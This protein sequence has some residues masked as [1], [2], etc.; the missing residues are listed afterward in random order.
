MLDSLFLKGSSTNVSGTYTAEQ[1]QAEAVRLLAVVMLLVM[2][3]FL[4]GL[5][6]A[7]VDHWYYLLPAPPVYLVAWWAYQKQRLRLARNILFIGTA[8]LLAWLACTHR[9]LG[10]EYTLLGI[11][12]SAPLVFKKARTVYL[13]VVILIGVFVAYS[14]YDAHTPFVADPS[15]DYDVLKACIGLASASVVF[16][17]IVVYRNR[18]ISYSAAIKQQNIELDVAFELKSTIENELHQKNEE[19]RAMTEQLNWIVVQKSSELQVYLDAIN[20]HIQSAI[21][22][23]HA[24]FV[25]VNEPFSRIS[26]FDSADLMGQSLRLLNPVTEANRFPHD[27]LAHLEQNKVWR[28]ELRYTS[29]QGSFFWCDQVLVPLQRPNADANYFLSLSLP[30][31]ERKLNDQARERTRA[32]LERITFQTSHKVRG[33][34]ARIQGLVNLIQHDLL[35]PDELKMVTE[36]L[37]DC[38]QEVSEATTDLVMFV[39]HHQLMHD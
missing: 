39:N 19:L 21:L 29:K 37:K 17:Q 15:M 34:L 6:L 30:I 35:T 10:L 2:A 4:V 12:C 24:N 26:G 33:P 20:M 1:N 38:T 8:V 3:S 7:R 25:K 16:I 14:W 18:V 9:K 31:T 5:V 23:E 28:G 22:D 13:Y 11:A 36:K 27:L 32:L